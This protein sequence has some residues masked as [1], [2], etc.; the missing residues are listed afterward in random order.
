[1]LHLKLLEKQNKQNPKQKKGQTNEI[2][3]KKKK[4]KKKNQAWSRGVGSHLVSSP[5]P[6]VKPRPSSPS[7]LVT[8]LGLEPSAPMY[9]TMMATASSIYVK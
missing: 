7:K 9:R 3:I 8:E 6:V 2:D 4:K 5:L 1:M